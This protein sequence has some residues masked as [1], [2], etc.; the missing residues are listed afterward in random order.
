MQVTSVAEDRRPF[1]TTARRAQIVQAA[2]ET[3]AEVG[4][5]RASFARIAERAEL[6]STRLISYHFAGKDE[7]IQQV[8]GEVSS[9]LGAF[10]SDKVDGQGTAAAA[11]RAYIEAK[12]EFVASHRTQMKALLSIFL[13]GGLHY[14]S[15][16]DQSVV[17]PVE[18][19]LRQGQSGGE[20]RDFDAHVMATTIQRAVDGLPFMLEADPD[21]DLRHHARE[22]V[23]LF[24]LATRQDLLECT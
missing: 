13:S 17:S 1:T 19:I 6:S 23:T 12:V 3:I 20:F 5:S 2:I 10:V 16:T 4:F 22:L 14:D 21:L 8:V 11:L 7:L 24:E 15:A 9:A 18:G